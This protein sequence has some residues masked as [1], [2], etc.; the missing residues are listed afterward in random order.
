MSVIEVMRKER[1]GT[2]T[3]LGHFVNR[4]RLNA[5]HFDRE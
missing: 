5:T 3:G 4:R 1:R 2:R